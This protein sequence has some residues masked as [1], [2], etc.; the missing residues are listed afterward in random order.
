MSTHQILIALTFGLAAALLAPPAAPAHACGNAMRHQRLE[1][2]TGVMAEAGASVIEQVLYAQKLATGGDHRN[3]LRV[4]AHAYPELMK[5]DKRYEQPKRVRQDAAT[6]RTPAAFT[7]AARAAARS[8][9]RTDGLV[10]LDKKGSIQDVTDKVAL[11]QLAWAIGV[12]RHAVKQEPERSDWRNHLADAL[13]R[14]PKHHAEAL[15]MLAALDAEGLLLDEVR[16]RY[17]YLTRLAQGPA[18]AE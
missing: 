6:Q 2:P 1:R 9:V 4:L 11:R 15:G 18:A 17:A 10:R 12:W 16:G 14:H 8:I 7:L 3:A 13:S 5:L